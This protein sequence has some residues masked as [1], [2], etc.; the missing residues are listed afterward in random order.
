MLSLIISTHN[1]RALLLRLLDALAKQEGSRPFEVIVVADG[2]SDDTASVARAAAVPFSL[3]VIEQ[4]QSGLAAA[5]N[6][7]AADARGDLL[8]FSDDDIVPAPDFLGRMAEAFDDASVDVV[9]PIVRVADWVPDVLLARE[10]RGWDAHGARV[11]AG[12]APTMDDIHFACTGVRR[13]CFEALGG[14]DA[15]FTQG[16]AWGREDAEFAYRVLR[17]GHRVLSRPDLVVDSDCVTDPAAYLRRARDLGR[18]DV[19][20]ARKHPELAASLFGE[21]HQDA[22]ITRAVGAMV[23][24]LPQTARMLWPLRRTVTAVIRRGWTGAVLYRFWLAAWASE[25][26]AGV[27]DAGGQSL[28][29]TASRS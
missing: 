7:G 12:G 2:C 28:T 11:M 8:L 18:N 5:R 29:R 24:T 27:V 9:L 25:Y 10:Q 1:R 22:R 6:R 3:S 26:W 19:R 20:L 16:G 17:N 4:P 21:A 14:F 23:L 13:T 15:T